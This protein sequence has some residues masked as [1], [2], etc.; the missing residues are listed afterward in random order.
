MMD[1]LMMV[2]VAGFLGLTVWLISG[3][4]HLIGR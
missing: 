4:T 2:L 3:L 1:I